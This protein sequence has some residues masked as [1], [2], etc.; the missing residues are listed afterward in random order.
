MP[1]KSNV[2]LMQLENKHLKH[3]KS[4]AEKIASEEQL[5]QIATISANNDPEL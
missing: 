1:L 3:L 5:E 4:N 2:E